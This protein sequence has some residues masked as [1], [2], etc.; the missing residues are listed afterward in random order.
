MDLYIDYSYGS[1]QDS[2]CLMAEVSGDSDGVS[3]QVTLFKWWFHVTIERVR[4]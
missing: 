3:V 4:S 1:I 2:W